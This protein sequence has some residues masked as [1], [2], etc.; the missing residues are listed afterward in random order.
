MESVVGEFAGLGVIL[1][2]FV[3]EDREVESESELDGVAGGKIDAVGLFVGFLGLF[4]DFFKLLVLGVLGDVAVV[5]TN[6]LDEEGLG[7][8]GA[9]AVEDAAVDHVN[10]L[11]A[12]TH[13]LFLDLLLVGKKGGVELRVLGVLLDGGNSAASSSLSGDEVLESDRQKVSLIGVNGATLDNEDFLEEVNHVFEA[14]S[15]LG[16]T[17]EEYLLFNVSHLKRVFCTSQI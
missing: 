16:D 3:V 2:D 6:H 5:V 15:L 10:D 4:L 14:L 17:G 11:L 7:L 13:K 9:V 12:V 8:I 1:E